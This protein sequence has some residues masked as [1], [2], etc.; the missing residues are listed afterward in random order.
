MSGKRSLTASRI[1]LLALL[2][3]TDF[4]TFFP[5]T[6][7]KR[8]VPISL[9]AAFSTTNPVAQVRPL[10]LTRSNWSSLFRV[11]IY[12]FRI[13]DFGFWVY[14]SNPKSKIQNPKSANSL[15]LVADRQPPAALGAACRDDF[16][17]TFGPHAS[18]ES[19]LALAWDTLR[20]V[21]TFNHPLLYLSYY[22]R[23]HGILRQFMQPL[24]VMAI[25]VSN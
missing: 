22:L 17:T 16:A 4:P 1:N 8:L 14:V 6:N 12:E 5:A 23:L 24:Y 20:L 13:L 9:R 11:S 19:M 2:R 3:S 18:Q 15:W 21:S 7:P 25:W 10:R